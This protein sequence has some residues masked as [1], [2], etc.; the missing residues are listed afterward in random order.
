MIIPER[1]E[2]KQI[3]ELADIVSGGTPQTTVSEYWDGNIIWVV[4]TDITNQ[5][6]K[7]I[8]ASERMITEL[9]L[10]NSAAILL[11]KG[12]ILLCSRA[13]IGEL[14][15]S[16]LP[17]T[18]NQGFKN[19]ICYSEIDNEYIYYAIQPLKKKLLEQASGSTFLEISKT[20]LGKIEILMPPLSE[21][22]LIATALSETDELI[23]SLEKLIAKKL[24]IK[25]GTMQELLTGKRRLPGFSGDWIEKPLKQIAL[26]IC[27]GKKNNEDKNM[28]GNYPFFVRSQKIETIN[29]YSYDGEAIIVPGEGNIG[30]IF[31]YIV[32][33][34]DFHQRVYKISN[35]IPYVCGLYIFFYMKMLFGKYAL[36]NTS[37]ATVDSL[38]LPVFQEFIV[39]FPK[40]KEEQTAIAQILSDM[41]AEIDTLTS[42]L[43]KLR[44]IKQGMMSEL[45]TGR[46]RLI[47]SKQAEATQIKTEKIQSKPEK[48]KTEKKTENRK[49]GHNQAIEEAVMMTGIVNAFYSDKY[50]LGRKKVQ[51]L[52][53]LLNRHQGT[54]TSGFKEKAAGPYD[55][56]LRYSIEPLA[57]RNKYII[58]KT[59]KKGTLFFKGDNITQAVGYI[60]NWEKTKNIQW[61]LDQFKVKPIDELELLATVD[62]AK[63]ELLE[64]QKPISMQT[65]KDYIQNSDE[66]RAKLKREIFSNENITRAI[67]WSGDLF[68]GNEN[69]KN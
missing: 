37:K 18:T 31:H 10:I 47:N 49:T 61:L 51:K 24:A 34:F 48:E 55:E 17:V 19:L 29:S 53:Y 1:W 5:R 33:K 21:Q 44:N 58:T 28:N 59:S 22:Y 14:A 40:E 16:L 32:G 30:D 67:K 39:K 64:T 4:P 63:C 66:W 9:G 6:K 15:I 56:H 62:K 7:Y 3:Q 46:I 60:Q 43:N 23:N 8:N 52:M 25:Q 36:E 20:E 13:T 41:D 54:S 27:T 26:D 57:V 50:L 2:F 65:V 38:R 45:L 11:P 42:K 69:A 68:G 12:T 35:F